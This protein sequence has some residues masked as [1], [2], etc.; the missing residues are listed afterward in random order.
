MCSSDLAK[1]VRAAADAVASAAVYSAVGD[2]GAAAALLGALPALGAAGT[3]GVVAYGGGRA[4]GVAITVQ[5]P[6]PGAAAVLDAL[7]ADA[8]PA[9]YP[10]VLRA[11]TQLTPNG[12]TIPMGVPPESAMFV[13]G[14]HEMLQMLGGRCEDCGTINTPPSIH[15]HCIACEI[16]RAHV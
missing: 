9:N 5:A 14:A 8:R 1:R 2:T 10:T 15:P 12:E 6:V 13:R 7:A 3:V 4:T 16:G 11:R